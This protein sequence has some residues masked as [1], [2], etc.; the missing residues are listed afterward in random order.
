MTRA[1]FLAAL[2]LASA[3]L[4]AQVESATAV[5]APV[6]PAA[7]AAPLAITPLTAPLAGSLAA[8][9]APALASPAAALPAAALLPPAP[10]AALPAAPAAVSPGAPSARTAIS[11]ASHEA[12]ESS[13]SA[14]AAPDADAAP[15]VAAGALFDGAAAL[16]S[17]SVAVDPSDFPGGSGAAIATGRRLRALV[18]K[19]LAPSDL[20]YPTTL[21]AP[22]AV[23][24]PASLE[25]AP[26][27]PVR[28]VTDVAFASLEHSGSA[29]LVRLGYLEDGRPVALKAYHLRNNPEMLDKFMLE[30]TRSAK[31][32]SDLGVGP[33]FHGVWRDRDGSWNVAFDVARGDFSGNPINMRTFHD[34]ETIL[35]RLHGAGVAEFSDLQMYRDRDGRLSVIDPGTAANALRPLSPGEEPRYAAYARLEQLGPAPAEDGRRYLAWLKASRPASYA[36]LHDLIARRNDAYAGPIKARYPDHFGASP[37]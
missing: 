13:L 24:L 25:A 2:L 1:T 17:R 18:T 29:G 31:L 10:V 35:E 16:E 6:L 7:S 19:D 15:A 37:R 33:R 11:P 23:N 14:A 8:P 26:R 30:E 27:A 34:L 32:L 4:R 21:R 9:L 12:A 22:A 20:P 5:R 36:M 3:P 28:T